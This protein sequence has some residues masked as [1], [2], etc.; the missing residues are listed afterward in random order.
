MADIHKIYD[1]AR[2]KFGF[3]AKRMELFVEMFGVTNVT[4][5]LDVGGVGSY[6]TPL[7][8]QLRVTLLNIR[9]PPPNERTE[10]PSVVGD[11]CRLPYA[12]RAFDIVFSNSVIEH[13]GSEANQEA[14]AH[15]VRRVGRSYY[16][17]VPYRWGIFEPHFLVPFVHWLPKPVRKRLIYWL[18]PWRY[19][20]KP[21]RAQSD[22]SVD[23]IKLLSRRELQTLFPDA[24]IISEK[25]IWTTKP[26]IA[27]R[28][29]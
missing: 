25:F 4:R 18:S 8:V 13:V 6:W 17:Q 10:F 22:R 12:D 27:T 9:P 3:Q 2:R 16:V 26:L 23:G 24:K 29:A 5:I 21:T 15:E 14:F 1:F 11:G 20:A 19:I 28:V 7:T